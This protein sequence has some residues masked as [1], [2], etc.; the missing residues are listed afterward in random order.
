MSY[1]LEALRKSRPGKVTRY[2]TGSGRGAGAEQG[3]GSSCE[4][5]IALGLDCCGFGQCCRFGVSVL[6]RFSG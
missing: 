3:R 6:A 2:G 4:E 5:D 1:I